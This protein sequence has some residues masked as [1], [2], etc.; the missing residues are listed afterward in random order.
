MSMSRW[1]DS[2]SCC[3]SKIVRSAIASCPLIIPDNSHRCGRAHLVLVHTR[4]IRLWTAVGAKSYW[5]MSRTSITRIDSFD[6]RGTASNRMD[7]IDP[8]LL[9]L[10]KRQL[11]IIPSET[12]PWTDRINVSPPLCVASVWR[13]EKSNDHIYKWTDTH[14]HVQE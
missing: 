8:R 2:A 11:F 1:H 12:S 13:R 7:D 14:A 5:K 4:H 3:P 6:A 9:S 10:R